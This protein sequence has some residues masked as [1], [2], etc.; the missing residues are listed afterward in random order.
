MKETL[1]HELAHVIQYVCFPH[2]KQA[3]GPEWKRIMRDLGFEPSTYHSMERPKVN[4]K[5][6]RTYKKTRYVYEKDGK[7]VLLIKKNHTK[8][9]LDPFN[10]FIVEKM[11]ITISYS[12]YKG[13]EY[14]Y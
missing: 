6:P 2:A 14:I 1:A 7:R 8:L 4:G 10:K 12:N 9:A 5:K 11:G 13:I 3:H